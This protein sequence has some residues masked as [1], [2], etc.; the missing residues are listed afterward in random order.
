MNE[1]Y[2]EAGVKRRKT[3]KS[4]LTKASII[5]AVVVVF[6][7]GNVFLGS[8]GTFVA[9]IMV[10]GCFYIFPRFNVEYEY[11]YCDGQLDFDRIAGNIKR[12]NI[13]RIDFDKVEMVAPVNSHAFDNYKHLKLTTRDFTSLN[14]DAK[15][16]AIVFRGNRDNVRILFEPSEKMLA[17]IKH[18]TPRKISEI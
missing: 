18:K 5:L 11:I 9:S 12:K 8:I 7:F 14:P 6:G 1:S 4:H 2:V 3:M 13:L 16:Y 17:C 10:V 15:V